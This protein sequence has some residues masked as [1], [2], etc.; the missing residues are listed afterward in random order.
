MLTFQTTRPA[1]CIY[2]DGES[3]TLF[4]TGQLDTQM[5]HIW[6]NLSGQAR[7]DSRWALFNEYARAEGLG[8]WL[9]EKKLG[10]LGAGYEGV[11]RMNAGFVMIW[12]NFTS[13]SIKL[14]SHLN[15]TTPLLPLR[16]TRDVVNEREP[17]PTALH[18]A[19]PLFPLPIT[20]ERLTDA[21]ERPM[22]PGEFFD[23]RREP[24]Q[25]TQTFDWYLSSTTHYGSSRDIQDLANIGSS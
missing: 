19:T 14:V 2:F 1:K 24:F 22:P 9:K 11:V 3:A 5:L 23:W 4:G 25:K 21:P 20:P 13:P 12:C 16:N 17:T 15:V 7:Q 10:G 6:G 8:N 18:E